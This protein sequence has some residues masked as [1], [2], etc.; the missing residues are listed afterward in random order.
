MAGRTA[1][2]DLHIERENS[3]SLFVRAAGGLVSLV[4]ARGAGWVKMAATGAE[5]QALLR[6]PPRAPDLTTRDVFLWGHVKDPVFLSPVPQDLPELR[7]RII[8]AVSDI[9]RDMLQRIWAEMYYQLD[10]GHVTKGGH[11]EHLRGMHLFPSVCRVL[12]Y[13]LPFKCTDFIKCV[14]ELWLTLHRRWNTSYNKVWYVLKLRIKSTTYILGGW[15]GIRES[16][17]RQPK[18]IVLKFPCSAGGNDSSP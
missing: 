9:D 14:R 3:P 8:A 11:A 13:F 2:C 15:L 7:R 6:W 1:T 12:Q 16:S 18:R 5:D 4:A 17:S 10:D